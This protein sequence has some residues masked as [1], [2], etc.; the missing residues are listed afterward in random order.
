MPSSQRRGME[1]KGTEPR[2][3]RRT[4]FQLLR[5]VGDGLEGV[6]NLR[7]VGWLDDDVFPSGD[8]PRNLRHQVFGNLG[9][10]GNEFAR[11]PKPL[12]V[13]CHRGH[14]FAVGLALLDIGLGTPNGVEVAEDGSVL[15]LVFLLG[16]EGR[17]RLGSECRVLCVRTGGWY[18]RI[19]VVWIHVW[20]GLTGHGQF[21]RALIEPLFTPFVTEVDNRC[22]DCV[23]GTRWA[24]DEEFVT[25]KCL[26]HR[27]GV[28]QNADFVPRQRIGVDH[29]LTKGVLLDGVFGRGEFEV[30]GEENPRDQKPETDDESDQ[31]RFHFP[32]STFGTV[33]SATPDWAAWT[34][35]T[36]AS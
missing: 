32:S 4:S 26:L 35:S 7:H 31:L 36:T 25:G 19:G 30:S 6:L 3:R 24:G 2:E 29:H 21:E 15:L 14:Q 23:L 11:Q 9:L 12:G 28:H 27:Y 17:L 1:W 8:L 13:G 20:R 34:L 10:S 33:G 22:L 16:L 5:C 18:W